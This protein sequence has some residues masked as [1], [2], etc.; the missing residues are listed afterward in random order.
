MRPN[1]ESP[2]DHETSVASETIDARNTR[3]QFLLS[4]LD[5]FERPLTAYAMRLTGGDL[6]SARDA[7]QHAFMQLC[8]QP[9]DSVKPKLAPWLYTVCR[10]QI[11]D[12]HK[13]SF[14]QKSSPVNFDAIDL[15]ASD[16]A[17]V[18]EIDDFLQSLKGLFCCLCDSEREVI[19]LWSHGFDAKEIGGILDKKP[20]TVRVNLHRAIKRLRQ[21]PEVTKWLERATGQIVGPDVDRPEA[22]ES[23]P[24]SLKPTSTCNGKIAPSISGEQ[25]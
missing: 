20:S 2:P 15:K 3:K 23:P 10:N 12:E 11:L 25:S 16:P 19:E 4:S 6:H 24:P 17:S 7:V 14:R 22:D 13:S 5:R 8:K 21:H 1:K 18:L 9:M